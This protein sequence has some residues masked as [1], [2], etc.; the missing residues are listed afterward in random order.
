[1][2]LSWKY[3]FKIVIGW[4]IFGAASF[5]VA[6]KYIGGAATFFILVAF[7]SWSVFPLLHFIVAAVI[8]QK[9][10][11]DPSAGN[12]AVIVL[13]VILSLLILLLSGLFNYV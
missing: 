12:T 8:A 10:R 7:A 9:Q 6:N 13:C 1:M 11:H 2:V 5:L 3:I 4:P